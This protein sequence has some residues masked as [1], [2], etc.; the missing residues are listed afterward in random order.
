MSYI[1]NRMTR[2]EADKDKEM[3]DVGGGDQTISAMK[4]EIENI[5]ESLEDA[6][7][8]KLTILSFCAKFNGFLKMN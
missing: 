1:V 5:K 6:L 2:M 4:D 3:K 7:I 8:F